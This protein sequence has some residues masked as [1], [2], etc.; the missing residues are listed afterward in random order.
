M[1]AMPIYNKNH[2]KL[3]FSRTTR[4]IKDN[5]LITYMKFLLKLN[6]N[7]GC[8]GNRSWKILND[9]FY[10]STEPILMKFHI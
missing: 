6:G 1:A 8:H 2:S 10:E 3:F 7:F 4:N 9:I 5:V